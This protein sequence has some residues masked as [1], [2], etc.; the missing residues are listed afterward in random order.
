MPELA[1]AVERLFRY[2]QGQHVRWAEAPQTPCTVCQRRWTQRDILGP[3]VEYL[4]VGPA[5]DH[6]GDGLPWVSEADLEPWPEAT[7][8]DVLP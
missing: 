5:R 1:R 8:V 4:L 6:A 2:R 3:V 7:I